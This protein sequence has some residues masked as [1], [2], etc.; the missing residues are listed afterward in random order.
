MVNLQCIPLHLHYRAK[1]EFSMSCPLI[2]FGN[3]DTR[4]LTFFQLKGAPQHLTDTTGQNH[5]FQ[6]LWYE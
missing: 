5:R 3:S 6:N 2:A 1:C 4:K